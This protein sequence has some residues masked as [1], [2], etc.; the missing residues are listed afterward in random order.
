MKHPDPVTEHLLNESPEAS[1]LFDA[2]A[3]RTAWIASVI[4]ARAEKQ[5][6]QTDLANAIGVKQPTIAKLESGERDPK[7]STMV[8]VC[9]A[10]EISEL[11]VPIMPKSA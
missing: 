6:T 11:R 8:A 5:W 3:P 1:A 10:L 4:N 9:R 7:L 2:R